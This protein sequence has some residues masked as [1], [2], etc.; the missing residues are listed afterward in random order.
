MDK[1]RLIPGFQAFL[2]PK[3][4]NELAPAAYEGP[5]VILNDH[6]S[7][8]DALV[9][10]PDSSNSRSISVKNVPLK[11]FTSDVGKRL[12]VDLKSLLSAAGIRNRTARKS[13]R[14]ESPTGNRANF[15]DILGELWT[16]VV[17]PVIDSLAYEVHT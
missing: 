6:P 2:R 1:I 15:E 3:S 7:H 11:S 5:V 8:S 13:E 9:L 4:F 12:L 17:K 16:C 10:I 14:V